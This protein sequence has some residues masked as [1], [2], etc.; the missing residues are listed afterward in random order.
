MRSHALVLA[1]VGMVGISA[2]TADSPDD[3]T[4]SNDQFLSAPCGGDFTVQGEIEKKYAALGGRRSSLGCPVSSETPTPTKFGAFNAFQN[5]SIYWSPDTGAHEVHGA[6]RDAWGRFGWENGP[7]GFP[8]TDESPGAC[9]GMRYS[10]F[11]GG[12]VVWVP[13]IGAH[14]SY[15]PVRDVWAQSGFEC[16]RF[17]VPFTD[18]FYSPV[19]TTIHVN[20]LQSF[21]TTHEAYWQI[22]TQPNG[23]SAAIISQNVDGTWH[24]T[25]S[26]GLLAWFPC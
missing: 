2:C 6:I 7:L 12:A 16:G 25:C 20:A 24:A 22:F 14:T 23:R 1:L 9:F 18:V 19:P 17:G 8:T 5:G 13:L 3:A 10:G 15:G 21:D 4:E 11:Q 26:L